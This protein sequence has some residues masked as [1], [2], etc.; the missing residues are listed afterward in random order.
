MT[1]PAPPL[2]LD[3]YAAIPDALPEENIAILLQRPGL[4]LERILSRGQASPEGFWYDQDEDEWV[5]LVQGRARLRIEGE[6]ADRDLTPGA[7]IL[8]PAHCR[9]RVTWTDPGQ[10]TVW[11][12]LFLPAARP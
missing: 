4:R 2:L 1:A 9:H 3:L 8:L 11:L 7:H 12:A 6:P 5:M 10:T